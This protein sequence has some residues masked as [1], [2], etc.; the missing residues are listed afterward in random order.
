MDRSDSAEDSS[1]Q[2]AGDPFTP[3]TSSTALPEISNTTIEEGEAIQLGKFFSVMDLLPVSLS[4]SNA[5]TTTATTPPSP[6]PPVTV[7]ER[8]GAARRHEGE[9][10]TSTAPPESATEESDD[11]SP[12]PPSLIPVVSE[13][14]AVRRRV[15][16]AATVDSTSGGSEMDEAKLRKVPVEIRRHPQSFS[17]PSPVDVV[18]RRY[19]QQSSSGVGSDGAAPVRIE[20]VKQPATTTVA[21]SDIFEGVEAVETRLVDGGECGVDFLNLTFQKSLHLI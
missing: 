15:Q 5:T 2:V 10:G 11:D 3:T 21:S 12:F 18:H 8:K 13:F 17:T 20:P 7:G 19:Q 16:P 9:V 4:E 6:Q 14:R 1:K